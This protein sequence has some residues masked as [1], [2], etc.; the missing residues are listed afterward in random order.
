ML[1]AV[2]RIFLSARP[3]IILNSPSKSRQRDVSFSM[4]STLKLKVK[5][6]LFPVF[7]KVVLKVFFQKLFFFSKVFFQSSF[8]APP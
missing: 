5:A 4:T 3:T 8:F 1:L 7:L 6:M 2:C